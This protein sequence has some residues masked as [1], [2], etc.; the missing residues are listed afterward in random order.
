VP[1]KICQS[2][3]IA[4]THKIA[5]SD[6]DLINVR[7]SARRLRDE[8]VRYTLSKIARSKVNRSLG[9][10]WPHVG[11]GQGGIQGIAITQNPHS[12]SAPCRGRDAGATGNLFAE[13]SWCGWTRERVTSRVRI[14]SLP[15]TS[16]CRAS[17][18][19]N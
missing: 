3:V 6:S 11:G 9:C 19:R 7:R 2:S 14:T 12:K 10:G 16:R 5:N 8:C 1:I 13:V 4:C 18:L 17:K 15:S